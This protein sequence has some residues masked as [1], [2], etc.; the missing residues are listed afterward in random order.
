M[1]ERSGGLD[2]AC[3]R[4]QTRDRDGT[5]QKNKHNVL[6]R[7]CVCKGGRI[8]ETPIQERSVNVGLLSER[9][10]VSLSL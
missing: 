2:W 10:C 6:L 3:E 5:K 1:E 9:E 4:A 7:V 8:K